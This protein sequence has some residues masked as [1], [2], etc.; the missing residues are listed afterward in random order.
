MGQDLTSDQQHGMT[1]ARGITIIVDVHTFV[2]K[3]SKYYK[4]CGQRL[5]QTVDIGH[6]V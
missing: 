1:T 6:T 3:H 5:A 2:L 4:Q